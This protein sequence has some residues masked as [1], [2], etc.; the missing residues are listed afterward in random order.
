MSEFRQLYRPEV[1]K[2]GCAF[3][4][5]AVI[6]DLGVKGKT[7]VK[8]CKHEECIYRELDGYES[9]KDY[10]KDTE[11]EWRKLLGE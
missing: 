2:R 1:N 11:K 5:D 4:A 8:H 6:V 10:L 7:A 3:C 9:Y